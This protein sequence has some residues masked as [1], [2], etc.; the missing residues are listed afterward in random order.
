MQ[1]RYDQ[2]NII[3][4]MSIRTFLHKFMSVRLFVTFLSITSHVSFANFGFLFKLPEIANV[5]TSLVET[6]RLSLVEI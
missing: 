2:Y 1:T 3:C 6:A 5:I 4:T